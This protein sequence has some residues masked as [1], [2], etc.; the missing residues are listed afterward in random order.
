MLASLFEISDLVFNC[1]FLL[2]CVMKVIALGWYS[3]GPSAYIRNWW[4]VSDFVLLV[5]SLVCT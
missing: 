2:E 3:T 4:N 1:V 5:G